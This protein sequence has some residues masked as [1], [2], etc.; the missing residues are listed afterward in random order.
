MAGPLGVSLTAFVGITLVLMGLCAVAIGRAMAESWRGWREVAAACCALGLADRFLHFALAGG[1]LLD[2]L[3]FLV[4]LLVLLAIAGVTF[5]I[6]R[7]RKM[8]SQYPWLYERAGLWSWRERP[9][10]R[11]R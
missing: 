5:K 1:R 6:A 9:A 8:T 3:G 11:P 10:D 7:A 4:H 2:P